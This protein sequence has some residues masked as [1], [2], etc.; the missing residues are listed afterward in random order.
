M[1]GGR[2]A[3]RSLG[4]VQSPGLGLDICKEVHHTPTDGEDR[5]AFRYVDAW[6]AES[7]SVPVVS[8]RPVAAGA[9]GAGPPSGWFVRYPVSLGGMPVDQVADGIVTGMTGPSDEDG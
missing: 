7:D 6:T 5:A 4:K 2:P 1:G 3:A 8:F 9:A